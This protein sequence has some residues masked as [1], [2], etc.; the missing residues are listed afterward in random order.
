MLSRYNDFSTDL[1]L[2]KAIN[3]SFI[4]Y[5]KDFLDNL[6]KLRDLKKSQIAKD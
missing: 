1:I 5:T 2:E 4:Y 6:I 3:E